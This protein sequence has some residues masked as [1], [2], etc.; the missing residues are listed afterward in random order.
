[1]GKGK[2]IQM[3]SVPATFLLMS[4]WRFLLCAVRARRRSVGSAIFVASG[5]RVIIIRSVSYPGLV[6]CL[7]E[8]RNGRSVSQKATFLV[9]SCIRP[10]TGLSFNL[11]HRAVVFSCCRVAIGC[12][13]LV[14]DNPVID[15]KHRHGFGNLVTVM[16]LGPRSGQRR[17]KGPPMA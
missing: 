3:K 10:P 5:C 9:P 15:V 13:Y 12:G 11:Q 17:Y 7:R 1:M 2:E 14:G 8:R 6:L 4:R 16:R